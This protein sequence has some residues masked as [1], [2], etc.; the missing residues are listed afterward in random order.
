MHKGIVLLKRPKGMT[1]EEFK[2]WFLGPHLDFSR[3]RPEVLRYTGSFTVAPGPGSPYKDGEP[4]YDIVAEIWCKD[5][6]SIQSAYAALY[7]A[8]G[9]KDSQTHA[10]TRISF[11]AEEHVVFDKLSGQQ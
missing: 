2:A 8:G 3:S 5:L 1:V 10:G 4:D 7:A 9:V 11:I 6:A